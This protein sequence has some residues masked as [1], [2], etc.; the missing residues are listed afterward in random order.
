M[1][2]GGLRQRFRVQNDPVDPVAPLDAP[3]QRP[4]F[5]AP[6]L[7]AIFFLIVVVVV[8]KMGGGEDKADGGDTDNAAASGSASPSPTSGDAPTAAPGAI[9]GTVKSR[10]A[11]AVYK[12]PEIRGRTV[13]S[14]DH[15]T[16]VMVEC[17]IAG[18]T[19]YTNGKPD[20]TW[21]RIIVQGKQGYV[22]VAQVDTGGVIAQ[23]VPACT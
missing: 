8:V 2:L 4:R 20:P 12:Q 16:K 19:Q 9:E 10:V 3:A 18:Q 5:L 13:L 23:Q 15:G 21:A 6:L 14:A 11:M 22:P 17:T 7:L 1:V